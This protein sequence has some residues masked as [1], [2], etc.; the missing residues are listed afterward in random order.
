MA[1]LA[2]R[3]PPV[4]DL[5]TEAERLTVKIDGVEYL[6]RQSN[7]LSLANL[8]FIE[9]TGAR[10]LALE[11]GFEQGDLKEREEAE[12]ASLLAQWCE[13]AI[14]APQDVIEKVGVLNRALIIQSFLELSAPSLLRLRATAQ[15]MAMQAARTGGRSSPASSGSSGPP[16]R[17]T[18]SRKS[19]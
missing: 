15:R 12:Y 8:R 4:L 17:R 5:T 1:S 9:R 19:R 14:D 10:L 7:D 16:A 6:L 13:L 18:G 11:A 2:H 3:P